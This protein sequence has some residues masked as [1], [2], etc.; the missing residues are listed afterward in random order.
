MEDSQFRA[1]TFSLASFS[2]LLALGTLPASI[3]ASFERRKDQI[4]YSNTYYGFENC[5]MIEVGLKPK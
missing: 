5:L 2:I 4:P 1:F 3:E